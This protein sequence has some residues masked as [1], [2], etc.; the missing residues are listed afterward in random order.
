MVYSSSFK[1]L[2][3][4]SSEK[5]FIGLGN[6]NAKI[7]IVGK[8]VSTDISSKKAI[9]IQ[10]A[11][12]YKRNRGDWR[13]NI[14]SK[15]SQENVEN[16]TFDEK[17]KGEDIKNNPLFAF[18]G[19]IKKR[20]SNTWKKYQKLHDCIFQGEIDR[21][22]SIPLTFQEDFFITEMSNIPSPKTKDAQSKKEFKV[23]L[24][25]RKEEFFKSSYIQN[26]P[27]IVLACS[28]YIWNTNKERQIDDIFGV[29]F[30]FDQKHSKGEYVF[31]KRNRFWTH[32][33]Q[34]A[35]KLVIHTRQLSNNVSDEMLVE[36][37]K[38]IK[39]HLDKNK[40]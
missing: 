5:T 12:T 35:T 1:T 17:A 19:A 7:L 2:V 31:T 16:W 26:F 3:E 24:A 32:Y 21:N 27:V 13:I 40:K 33:N 22:T 34:D 14:S 28:N 18:K 9:E 8:E 23:E 36:M 20:T 37:G 10:N 29:E 30:D 15:I 4:K 38:I 11:I 25:K 6:P 39:Q